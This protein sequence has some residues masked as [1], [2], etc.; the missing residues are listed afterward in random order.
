MRKRYYSTTG[1]QYTFPVVIKQKT[2][3]I[4]FKG[5]GN[6]YVTSDKDIQSA[7]EGNSRFKKGLIATDEKKNTA[8]ESNEYS[9]I[10]NSTKKSYP[11]VTDIQEAVEILKNE[12]NVT[13]QRLR[14][15]K[16]VKKQAELNNVSFP[17]WI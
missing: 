1:V 17:N 5:P 8:S 12:Y 7:I 2:K 16:A 11:E 6:D 13:H 9:N 10:V 14:T 4:E 15:P 3:W